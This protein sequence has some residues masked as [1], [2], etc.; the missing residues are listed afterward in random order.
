MRIFV[1]SLKRLYKLQQ[2]ETETVTNLQTLEKITEE[3][4]AYILGKDGK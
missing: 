4:A 3:E 1:E 2:I